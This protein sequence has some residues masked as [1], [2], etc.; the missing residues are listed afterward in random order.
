MQAARFPIDGPSSP[1]TVASDTAV[2]KI[3]PRV[4]SPSARGRRWARA[5]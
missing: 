1:S 3:A 4:R 2:C 5:V